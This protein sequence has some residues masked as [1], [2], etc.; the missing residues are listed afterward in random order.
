MAFYCWRSG[1]SP[2]CSHSGTGC[3]DVPVSDK[4]VFIVNTPE[5]KQ[6]F[7]VNTP[8]SKRVFI[9][10]TPES[11]QVFIV[12]TPESISLFHERDTGLTHAPLFLSVCLFFSQRRGKKTIS[13]TTDLRN[14]D[15]NT[16]ECDQVIS[17]L[18]YT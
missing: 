2:R 5:S 1:C 18:A 11:K 14:T 7:I 17:M 3:R 8:E 9:V 16:Q 15:R 13:S 12:N 10:N 6:V 4:E